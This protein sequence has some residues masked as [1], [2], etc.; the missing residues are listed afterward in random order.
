MPL[1]HLYDILS[2]VRL[3]AWGSNMTVEQA[4]DMVEEELGDYQYDDE[5]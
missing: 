2:R 3:E 5:Q 1:E 4:L